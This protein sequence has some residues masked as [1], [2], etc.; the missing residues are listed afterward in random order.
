MQTEDIAKFA[1]SCRA[2]IEEGK[3]KCDCCGPVPI[4]TS[5]YINNID[6]IDTEL[7]EETIAGD[8]DTYVMTKD[9]KCIFLNRKE[10]RCMI[11]EERPQVCR[12]F[13]RLEN[14]LMK[15]PY[16]KPNGNP[17]SEAKRKQLR[18]ICDRMIKENIKRFEK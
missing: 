9:C 12:D 3:C 18:R 5:V 13:G 8:D 7:I 10:N 16:L 14:P 15:C 1:K 17:W 11:Y 6:Y 2:V 4:P